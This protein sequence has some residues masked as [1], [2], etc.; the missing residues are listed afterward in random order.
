M[1]NKAQLL[2]TVV[3]GIALVVLS[4][5][6]FWLLNETAYFWVTY[7]FTLVAGGLLYGVL[8]YY[9]SDGKRTMREF[10]A[11]AP[12][13]YIAIQYAVIEIVLAAVFCLISGTGLSVIYFICAELILALV[14]GIRIVIA[15]GAKQAAMQPEHTA[16]IKTKSWQMVAA[17]V[18]SI[19]QRTGM[20]S[21]PELRAGIEKALQRLCDAVRYSDP[22]SDDSVAVLE[23][24]IRE[25]ISAV[26]SE[27]DRV[28]ASQDTDAGAVLAGIDKV[29]RLIEDRN[30]RVKILK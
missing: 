7:A 27:L 5:I 26:G 15:L 13:A 18:Q 1:K 2:T 3:F 12:Y 30:N 9:L 21:S 14:Y 29:E 22:M 4:A 19:Q 25:G 24:Q 17:D 16:K 6:A 10:P 23:G 28:I 20:I 11:N 8:M